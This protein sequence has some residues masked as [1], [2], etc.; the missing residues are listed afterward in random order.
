MHQRA[1]VTSMR[2][3]NKYFTAKKTYHAEDYIVNKSFVP[4]VSI[5]VIF[6]VTLMYIF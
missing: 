6:I 4:F 2:Y 1:S 5:V 3:G